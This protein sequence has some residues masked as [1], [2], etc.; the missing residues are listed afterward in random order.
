MMTV[1]PAIIAARKLLAT[2]VA[3]SILITPAAGIAASKSTASAATLA[4]KCKVS[5]D[6]L[7]A[8]ADRLQRAKEKQIG[9]YVALRSKWQGRVATTSRWAPGEAKKVKQDVEQ[10]DVKAK[11][12]A[13]DYNTQI[14]QFD[15]I[16]KS[17]VDCTTAHRAGLKKAIA[18]A[19]AGHIQLE[20]D[21]KAI[22]KHIQATIQPDQKEMVTKAHIEKRK[23]PKKKGGEEITVGGNDLGGLVAAP[24]Q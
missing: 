23:H 10:F 12:L 2:M 14:K 20:A 17:P 4:A 1:R 7:N 8:R 11:A 16:K 5:A 21:R 9:R 19:H 6:L 3:V 24:A 18:D 13:T 15:A 22:V